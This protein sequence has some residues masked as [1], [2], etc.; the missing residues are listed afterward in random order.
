MA[1][2]SSQSLTAA[3]ARAIAWWA[4]AFWVASV[5]FALV[6]ALLIDTSPDF[7]SLA[8]AVLLAV[9]TVLAIAWVTSMVAGPFVLVKLRNRPNTLG[10]WTTIVLPLSLGFALVCAIAVPVQWTDQCVRHRAIVPLV[11]APV[12]LLSQP[13]RAQ[14]AY[15]RLDDKPDCFA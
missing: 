5:L 11:A 10:V 1:A 14:V 9:V 8:V 13:A 12:I 7:A 15:L 3:R 2:L 6:L 4:L